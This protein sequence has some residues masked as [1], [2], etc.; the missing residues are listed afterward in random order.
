[1]A[2][3]VNQAWATLRSPESRHQYDVKLAEARMA[4]ASAPLPATTVRYWEG[5]DVAPNHGRRSRWL[6]ATAL[7]ACA[8]LAVLIVRHEQGPQAWSPPD[9]TEAEPAALQPVIEDRDLGIL[10]EAIAAVGTPAETEPV[11]ARAA[12]TSEVTPAVE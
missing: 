10:T 7:A 1:Y 9:V 12:P 2:T 11:A 8:V 6:L 4:G 3:R 5:D